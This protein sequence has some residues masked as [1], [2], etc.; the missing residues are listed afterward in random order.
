MT[1]DWQQSDWLH[2]RYDKTKVV[3]ESLFREGING[4]KGGLSAES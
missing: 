2:F 4:F 3:I 1:W